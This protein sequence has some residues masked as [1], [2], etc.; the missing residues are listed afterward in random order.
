MLHR[1]S[2]KDATR[3]W[4]STAA[5]RA[6]E[7]S[8]LWATRNALID[9]LAPGRS[10]IDVGG[11]FGIDGEVAFRAERA[12]ATRVVLFDG[13]DP[14][15]QFFEKHEAAESEITYVQGDL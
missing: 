7:G 13:M 1:R 9:R 15:Q 12:G 4:L 10:F 3:R 8:D 5:R 6:S 14:T 11:M 2:R